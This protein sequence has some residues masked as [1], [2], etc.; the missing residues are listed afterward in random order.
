M[1]ANESQLPDTPPE[2]HVQFRERVEEAFQSVAGVI[3]ASTAPLPTQTGDGSY[4]ASSKPTGLLDDLV[5]LQPS[6][7]RTVIDQAKSTLTGDPMNDKTDQME[8]L[9]KLASKFP[10]N[11]KAGSV[12]NNKLI[13][14]L[15]DDLQHPPVAQLGDEHRY[16]AADGSFNNIAAPQIGA[17][18]SHYARSVRPQTTQT[19]DLPDAADLFDNLMVRD[20]FKPHPAKLSSML[21]YLAS[22][23]IHDLFRTDRWDN[24]K[25]KTSSYLDLA[26]LYGCDQTEQDAMRTFRDGKIKPDCFSNRRI[27]GFPPGVGAM[28]IMFNRFHNYVVEQLASINE[29]RRFVKPKEDADKTAY[30]K[31]DNDLFQT[32]RLI[33]CGLYV[34]II[35]KDYVRTILNLNRTNS[36]WDLDPRTATLTGPTANGTPGNQVSAEFNL[37]YRW[38]ACVSEKDDKWTQEE[39]ARLFPGQDPSQVSMNQFL[40]GLGM[41]EN[42]LSPDPQKRSF[43]NLQRSV[44]GS[45]DDD[46]LVKILADGTEDV[47]GAFGSRNVPAILKAVEILG[48]KQARSWNLATLNEFRA[49]FNLEKHKS[50]KSI[51]SDTQIAGALEHF[52]DH[53]DLVEL[54]PGLVVEEAKYLTGFEVG[55][56]LCTDYTI[57]RAV[58]SDAVALIRGDRFYTVDYTPNSLTNWGFH[59]VSSDVTVDHGHVFY[60]LFLRAFPNHF[61]PNSI[62]A[63]YPFVTPEENHVILSKLEQVDRYDFSR[64]APIQQ[65][66]PIT[67]YA[68]CKSTLEDQQNF[69]VTWG[70]AIKFLMHNSG[71]EFGADFMLSGD[72]PVNANSRRVMGAALY[73]DKW[74]VEVKSFYENITLQLLR[75]KSYKVSGANQ[76]DIIRDVGNLAQVHFSAEVSRYRA[77]AVLVQD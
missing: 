2:Q 31:Y 15:Y 7:I 10:A 18:N 24:T 27:L 53:P 21:F 60:K 43:A 73:H 30:T 19:A 1:A 32:A 63:H 22:I 4:I 11:S 12:L 26:P 42:G 39:Y 59:E 41:W 65:P 74:E 40:T 5:H 46:A 71:K 52:Y 38:H 6:D 20:Q 50:F 17:A 54:Y 37:V 44:D 48:I 75:E 67:S 23:I 57:S 61:Q 9:L 77:H 64:P 56:G 62:Y 49:F 29:D 70:K 28:L 72:M 33:N 55:S 36:D 69:K 34:N 76:V 45:L 58:L 16:R 68:A 25:T 51:N 66:T 35:L 13:Q 3:N 47:A 14:Q 8:R